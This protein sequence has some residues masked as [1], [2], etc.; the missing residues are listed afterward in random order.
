MSA[1]MYYTDQAWFQHFLMTPPPGLS[2][3]TD[4]T[5][6]GYEEDGGATDHGWSCEHGPLESGS[7][8]WQPI[9]V[10]PATVHSE[11]FDKEDHLLQLRLWRTHDFNTPLTVDDIQKKLRGI[12]RREHQRA[13]NRLRRSGAERT[14][15]WESRGSFASAGDD[16]ADACRRSGAL[17]AP[18]KLQEPWRQRCA[19]DYGSDSTMSPSSVS[20]QH[21]AKD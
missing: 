12:R 9:D 1:A 20:S 7:V 6:W 8:T 14:D 5:H 15:S 4:C 18:M 13:R 10:A 11:Q 16:G 2:L 21:G 3:E 19:P 17:Y